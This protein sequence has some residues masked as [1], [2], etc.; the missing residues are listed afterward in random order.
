M[1]DTGILCH[2]QQF[3]AVVSLALFADFVIFDVTSSALLT[4]FNKFSIAAIE[5]VTVQGPQ[6]LPTE[7]PFDGIY[8]ASFVLVHAV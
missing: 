6:R 4:A 5:R 1:G 3:D 7:T 2:H 8:V